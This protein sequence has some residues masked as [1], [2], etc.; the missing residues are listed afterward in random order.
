M[1]EETSNTEIIRPILVAI[2]IGIVIS[3]T[4]I[5]IT[6]T[7]AIIATSGTITINGIAANIIIITLDTPK[8]IKQ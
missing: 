6:V 8:M 4:M 3:I 2:V 7:D 5:T 1:L